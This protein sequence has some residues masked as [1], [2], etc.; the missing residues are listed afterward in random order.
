MTMVDERAPTT[1]QAGPGGCER[2]PLAVAERVRKTFD[3]GRIVALDDVSL[4]LEGAEFFTLLGPSGC[5]KTTLL[6]LL[7]GFEHP[8][9]G[10]LLLDGRPVTGEPPNR[11]PVNTVF[12][13]YALFPHLTVAGNVA[14][15][16]ERQGLPR[17]VVAARVGEMLA[18]VRLGD[19]AG[20]RPRELSGGQQQR[21][22]LARALAPR[23]RLLLLDEPLSALDLKL[24][25]AMQVELKRLQR[26]TAVTFL[27]VTHD[28]DEAFS[29]SDRIAVMNEGRILQVAPPQTIYDRPNCRFV[30]DFTG[31]NV[32]PGPLVG[33]DAPFVAV[34]PDAV[35]LARGE[36]LPGRVLDVTFRGART[37]CLVALDAGP[38][39]AAERADLPADLAPGEAVACRFEAAALR[40]LEA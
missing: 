30:A 21:V 22:A 33:Q 15:G 12:Q 20:R 34:R 39:L 11:R 18:L 36:G 38:T 27:L 4:T 10:R 35:V 26:E 1:A 9:A 24:R 7:A 23:P 13:S 19:L 14:F 37:T 29:V 6:R 28:Q 8:D 31:A 25:R 32:L 16:L 3:D 40:P 5:G 2:R 17:S